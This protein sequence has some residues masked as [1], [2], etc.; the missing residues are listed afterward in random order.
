MAEKILKAKKREIGTKGAINQLRKDGFVP[1]VYYSKGKDQ[2]TFSVEEVVLN[3][4]VFTSETNIIQLSIDD[5]E[6]I[7]CI[8]KDVQFDPVTD[9]VV[10]IDM[11]GITLGQ[12]MQVEIPINFIGSAIGV[13]EGGILQEQLHKLEIECLPRN[14]P[15]N[16]EVDVTELNIG[17][18][19][20]VRELEYENV[21][22]LTNEEATVVSV[23][24]PRL[25]EEEEEEVD[26][27]VDVDEDEIAEPEVISKGKT[28][29]E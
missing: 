17:D 10:H 16:L 6:S 19:I 23:A 18:S 1:G 21:K 25:E 9:K 8:I 13:Q 11:Q 5:E 20:H 12:V 4:L 7:G 28:E 29:E 27:D 22:I 24:Q 26:V 2:I 3:K 14:I 15:Q